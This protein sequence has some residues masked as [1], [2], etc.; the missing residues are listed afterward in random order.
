MKIDANSIQKDASGA[1][2]SVV[3]SRGPEGRSER[4]TYLCPDSEAH[5]V[6]AVMLNGIPTD[7]ARGST[8]ENVMLRIC[9]KTSATGAN[10]VEKYEAESPSAAKSSPGGSDEIYRPSPSEAYDPSAYCKWDHSALPVAQR[11]I[12]DAG[13]QIAETEQAHA[14][15][16]LLKFE[17]VNT[18]A[19]QNLALAAA[20]KQCGLRSD[21]WF[22]TFSSAYAMASD[23]DIKAFQLTDAEL[24]AANLQGLAVFKEAIS[25][26]SC[27]KLA[28]SGDL[29]NLDRIQW[30]LTGGYH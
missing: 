14:S 29:D 3:V 2:A 9:S 26:T 17:A 4:V 20:V 16:R 12:C 8:S 23:E 27:A 22:T 1:L 19:M 13:D 10:D 7:V 24:A 18:K 30:K 15:G 11:K 6:G 25:H 28:R 21:R 5:E